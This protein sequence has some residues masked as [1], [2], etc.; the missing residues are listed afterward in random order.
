VEPQL[1]TVQ[2]YF[3]CTSSALDF[4]T[5]FVKKAATASESKQKTN[6]QTT[7]K[8]NGERSNSFFVTL[9]FLLNDRKY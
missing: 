5:S 4:S 9:L 8:K 1:L 2:N 6:K 7:K 3:P